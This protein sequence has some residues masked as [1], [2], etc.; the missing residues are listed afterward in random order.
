MGTRMSIPEHGGRPIPYDPEDMDTLPDVRRCELCGK[1]VDRDDEK[2][3][4][5]VRDFLNWM[6]ALWW[7]DARLVGLVHAR[8]M[9][10]RAPLRSLAPMIGCSKATTTRLW[11]RLQ[12]NAPGVATWLRGAER[13][14]GDRR[15]NPASQALRSNSLHSVVG[16]PNG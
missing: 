1:P 16:G 4:V 10:P 3:E 15:G 14:G 7:K 8:L 5:D 12:Q 11:Q 6:T 13:R 2:V 9:L